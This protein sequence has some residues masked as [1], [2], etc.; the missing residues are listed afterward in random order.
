PTND[1]II[2]LH[3]F[4]K[5]SILNNQTIFTVYS[6]VNHPNP[7]SRL[8]SMQTLQDMR[9]MAPLH[10]RRMRDAE[11]SQKGC[12]NKVMLLFMYLSPHI[13]CPIISF[14]HLDL[15][16]D[17]KNNVIQ[18]SLVTC[19]LTSQIEEIKNYFHSPR[20]FQ[21][22]DRTRNV[23]CLL[24]PCPDTHS[25]FLKSSMNIRKKPFHC[26]SPTLSTIYQWFS[27][28]SIPKWQ[29]G[30]YG[31]WLHQVDCL[32]FKYHPTVMAQPHAV[33]RFDAHCQAHNTINP[34]AIVCSKFPVNC[35]N[36]ILLDPYD[37]VQKPGLGITSIFSHL[38]VRLQGLWV[39]SSCDSLAIYL[40]Y[41]M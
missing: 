34:L 17:W 23:L 39:S 5:E 28:P 33:H 25:Q 13:Q 6:S 1:Q 2:H 4:T 7:D 16:T 21:Q 18:I 19:W 3:P 10:L 36:H 35:Y 24:L 12:W 32:S 29:S 27:I 30:K 14:R 38:D 31:E 11:D 41:T 20:K 37:V 22:R 8:F 15:T 26:S 9:L 40:T